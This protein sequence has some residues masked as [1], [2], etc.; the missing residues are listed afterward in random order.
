MKIARYASYTGEP[1]VVEGLGDRNYFFGSNG[2]GKSSIGN[3]IADRAVSSD[4]DVVWQGGQPLKTH[5]YNRDFI[6]RTFVSMDGFKGVFT[7]G[8]DAKEAK[9][10]I[11]AANAELSKLGLDLANQSAALKAKDDDLAALEDALTADCWVQKVKHDDDFKDALHGLRADRAKFKT[12][13]LTM[14]SVAADLRPLPE[15]QDKARTVFGEAPEKEGLIPGLPYAELVA[16]E[17]DPLLTTKILGKADVDI[18]ALIKHLGNSDWVGEGRGYLPDSGGKCPFCQQPLPSNL[19]SD[20]NDY[21][22]ETFVQQTRDY[23]QF[24]AEYGRLAAGVQTSIE[25][26]LSEPSRFLDSA[27]VKCLK[28]AFDAQIARNVERLVAKQKQPSRVVALVGAADVLGEIQTLVDATN[29]KTNAHNQTVDNLDD[30]RG[31]LTA[32]VWKYLVET[33]LKGTLDKYVADKRSKTDAKKAIEGRIALTNE[34]IEGLRE[35]VASLEKQTTSI[36]PAL[37]AINVLLANLGFTGFRLVAAEDERSYRLV[38]ADGTK[39]EDTLSE[40]EK[41]FVTFLY[42]YYLL[43]GSQSESG[44]TDDV[45]VVFDDPVSSLDSDILFIVSTLIRRVCKEAGGGDSNIKQVFV[46]THNVYFHKEVTFR[47][48]QMPGSETFWLVRKPDAVSKVVK[49]A[50]N[51]V[52]TSYQLLW[53]EIA[54][55]D[56]SSETIQNAMRRILEHY[57][58]VLGGIRLDDVIAEF[59]ESDQIVCHSLLSWVN[60]GSHSADDDLFVCTN[61]CADTYQRVFRGIFFKSGHEKHYLMMCPESMREVGA[62]SVAD[63][64]IPLGLVKP[65][66]TMEI[67]GRSSGV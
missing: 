24:V 42:F 60:D 67:P 66:S 5:V 52:Q 50:T 2:S 58:N 23:A 13:V 39:V 19:E 1:V 47:H 44:M 37:N 54:K 28:E 46:L 65:Q 62:E 20:L 27:N 33:E 17:S 6:A 41:S 7:L 57:F 55:E 12:Q 22:D 14:R 9:D 31:R 48:E 64:G 29:E 43:K 16:C 30:E 53:Q 10:R 34:A 26:L 45:V 51:P 56:L 59:S 32:Q 35:Q 40:G 8:E 3:V 11:D 36:M 63:E 21:F 25:H 4:S 15:L 61:D 49:Y 38:R 18:A